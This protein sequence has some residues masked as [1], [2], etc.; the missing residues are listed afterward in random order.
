VNDL[1]KYE[2]VL[3]K[4]LKNIP[5]QDKDPL[6]DEMKKLLDDEKRRG[7]GIIPPENFYNKRWLFWGIAALLL[8]GIIL[9]SPLSKKNKSNENKII[10]QKTIA[11][12]TLTDTSYTHK[13]LN[14]LTIISQNELQSRQSSVNR[15]ISNKTLDS[16]RGNLLQN[17]NV[18]LNTK[19]T[20]SLSQTNASLII[21]A[22]NS[23]KI[24]IKNWNKNVGIEE[25]YVTQKKRIIF[26]KSKS[27]VRAKQVNTN[28]TNEDIS[29]NNGLDKTYNTTGNNDAAALKNK[30][31]LKE[32]T[33]ITIEIQGIN[34]KNEIDQPENVS[35]PANTQIIDYQTK[36]ADSARNNTLAKIPAGLA[37]AL[38]SNVDSNNTKAALTKN[39][40]SNEKNIK[41]GKLAI[42]I[43]EQQSITT[44]CQCIYPD[45]TY[46]NPVRI[47][48]YLPLVYARYFITKKIFLQG[49]FKYAAPQYTPFIPYNA[50][51]QLFT[52]YY[53]A[54]SSVLRKT[55]YHQIPLSIN[56]TFL[57]HWSVGAG[58]MYNLFSSATTQLKVSKQVYGELNSDSLISLAIYERKNNISIAFFNYWAAIFQTQYQWNNFSAGIRYG[59]DLQSYMQYIMPFT[60]NRI[61]Q[62]SKQLLDVFIYY[63]LWR[64]K[65]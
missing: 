32:R 39:N 40:K 20:N 45:Q 3:A 33:M 36:I 5:L 9:V 61:D 51:V 10:P 27:A 31:G 30:I 8:I 29:T 54:T 34:S 44:T 23:P 24:T 17:S 42:G 18:I 47:T 14:S 2:K 58:L 21:R 35:I 41:Q 13:N 55:Y 11:K 63:Q 26:Y 48:D 7:G 37:A 50:S 53:I 52:S 12:D 64:K 38:S 4:Q 57:P 1:T 56:Y 6:W 46:T 22:T 65:K 59:V 62:K 15:N 19:H 49:G 25:E 60:N 28:P 43:G 16:E